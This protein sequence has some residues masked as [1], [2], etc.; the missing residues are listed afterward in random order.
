M[1]INVPTGVWT[2]YREAADWFIDTL[3]K[4]CTLVYPP[5]RVACD[6]CVRPAGSTS[7]NTYRHGGPMP[8]NFGNCP[9]CGGNGYHE[10]EQT[11]SITLRIYWDRRDW[12]KYA[13]S[14]QIASVEA[15]II[16]YLSDLPNLLKANELLLISN[17]N[18]AQYRVKLSGK[19]VPHGF[20]KNR[21]FRA[22]VESV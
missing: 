17:Q 2:K 11:G 1:A 19:P 10:E 8:F 7:N 4:S 14:I 16:G 20:F 9:M 5:K 12:L 15:M 6:N 22:F 18:Y 21:Y 13:N 3:G